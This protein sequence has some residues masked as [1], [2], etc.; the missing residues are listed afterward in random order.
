MLHLNAPPPIPTGKASY[1]LAVLPETRGILTVGGTRRAIAAVVAEYLD[2]PDGVEALLI[3]PAS[4]IPFPGFSVAESV[5][6]EMGIALLLSEPLVA[7]IYRLEPG[8]LYEMSMND[9]DYRLI[10]SLKDLSRSLG[11]SARGDYYRDAIAE[12]IGKAEV[13]RLEIMLANIERRHPEMMSLAREY[14]ARFPADLRDLR[15]WSRENWGMEH[16]FVELRRTATLTPGSVAFE[17]RVPAG[18]I[19]TLA[20]AMSTAH[21]NAVIHITSRQMPAG[22][23]RAESFRAGGSAEPRKAMH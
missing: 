9:A 1:G 19:D 22:D 12:I 8:F 20:L 11:A 3:D 21:Q 7:S 15:T 4:A 17:Y 23:E 14:L 5:S 10:N 18:L 16:H 6:Q 2:R 13:E